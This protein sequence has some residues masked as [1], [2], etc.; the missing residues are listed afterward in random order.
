MLVLGN[1]LPEKLN[2]DHKVQEFPAMGMLVA[3]TRGPL[4]QFYGYNV[5]GTMKM[6]P[7]QMS[8]SI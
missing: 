5:N 3:K 8:G 6:L 1:F 7:L 4:Y 2:P